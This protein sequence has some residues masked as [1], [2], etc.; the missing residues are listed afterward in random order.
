[1]IRIGIAIL[2]LPAST[3]G[4]TSEVERTRS[5]GAA[6]RISSKWVERKLNQLMPKLRFQLQKKLDFPRM[7]EFRFVHAPLY[8]RS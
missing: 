1:M 4:S 8:V 7:P 6:R 5:S 2:Q 3:R